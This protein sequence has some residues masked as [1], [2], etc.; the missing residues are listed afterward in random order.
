[1]IH[2]ILKSLCPKVLFVLA[3]IVLLDPSAMN[4]EAAEK[5]DSKSFRIFWILPIRTSFAAETTWLELTYC[6]EPENEASCTQVI[7]RIS[8]G[9]LLHRGFLKTEIDS[10]GVLRLLYSSKND[11]RQS[12]VLAAYEMNQEHWFPK[13]EICRSKFQKADC[14]YE[15][16]L[17]A[18]R[19][20]S[21]L[22]LRFY[23][24]GSN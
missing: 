19:T 23:F 10:K 7:K 5:F 4:L 11:F 16:L 21:D 8:V 24:E 9:Q 18:N 6:R 2:E 22:E 15:V 1:M 20:P 17:H 12:A 3:S 14:D 13:M